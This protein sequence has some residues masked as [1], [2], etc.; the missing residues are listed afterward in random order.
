M[1]LKEKRRLKPECAAV[2]SSHTVFTSVSPHLRCIYVV[3]SSCFR[4]LR[5]NALKS[6]YKDIYR[7]STGAVMLLAA[8]HTCDKVELIMLLNIAVSSLRLH[9]PD[10]MIML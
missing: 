9:L 8:L 10:S 1:R 2:G 5:S 7:P 3:L 6:R 4:F